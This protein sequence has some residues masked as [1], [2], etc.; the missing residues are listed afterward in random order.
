[1][2]LCCG[3]TQFHYNY[4]HS[5]GRIWNPPLRSA[6]PVAFCLPPTSAGWG[7]PALHPTEK[8]ERRAASPL[9]AVPVCAVLHHPGNRTTYPG[10]AAGHRPAG[11]KPPLSKGGAE[12]ARRRDSCPSA[13]VTAHK[14]QPVGIPP[15]AC[16]VH[17]PLTREARLSK[18][19]VH[20]LAPSAR[21]LR[22][23]AVGE[24]TVRLPE[25]F[26]AMARF[27]PSAPSGHLPR[28]GRL[29]CS[30]LKLHFKFHSCKIRQSVLQSH[31][32]PF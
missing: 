4:G 8:G 5:Y 1:M 23:Q 9:A 11:K 24:R 29:F 17:L 32:I 31:S 22:P 13:G 26:R 18:K 21:G 30:R 2:C 25:I 12:P 19:C 20:P 7:H 10:H 27:S 28:R 15:S 6:N 14:A 3:F 16:G